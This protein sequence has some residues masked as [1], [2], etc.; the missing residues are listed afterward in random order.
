MSQTTKQAVTECPGCAGTEIETNA[1]DYASICAS[2]GL[3]LTATGEPC[4]PDATSP[5]ATYED[6]QEHEFREQYAATNDTESRLLDAFGT[7][8]DITDR[9]PI[10]TETRIEAADIFLTAFQNGIT[11]SRERTSFVTACVRLA[12]VSTSKPVPTTGRV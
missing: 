3:V 6:T 2:C 8:E 12:S 5:D 10:P 11:D 1:Y 4:I 7:I 9:L